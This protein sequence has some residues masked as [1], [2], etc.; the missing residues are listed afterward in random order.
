MKIIFRSGRILDPASQKDETGDILVEDGCIAQIGESLEVEDDV[1]EVN[2]NGAWVLPGLIDL[3]PRL[4][5]P[6]FEYLETIDTA[7]K[8][9][10]AGGFTALAPSPQTKPVIDC[11]ELVR[12]LITLFRTVYYFVSYRTRFKDLSRVIS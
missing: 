2:A 12:Q 7:T 10:V 1:R 8:A 5:E 11:A 4:G 9:A 6:G 3:G